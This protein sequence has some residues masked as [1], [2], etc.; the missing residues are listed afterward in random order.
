MERSPQVVIFAGGLGTRLREETEFRPKPMVPVGPEPIL[1]HIMKI[2]RHYGFR[3]FIICLGYKG[4]VIREYFMANRYEGVDMTIN[5]RDDSFKLHGTSRDDWEVTLVQTGL[6]TMTG[7]R[8][9]QV[10]RYIDTENFFLTYGDGVSDVNIKNLCA[11]HEEQGKIATLTAVNL[12]S[13]FG[14]ITIDNS[15]VTAF[16]EKVTVPDQWINGGF[17]MLNRKVFEYCPNDPGLVFETD[18]LPQL[19]KNQQ[20]SAYQHSGFWQCMDTVR[21]RSILESLWKEPSP[22]WKVWD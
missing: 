1:W 19:V 9:A 21:D 2:Y 16:L 15:H 4:D 7:G 22:P 3:R 5:F 11:F 13:R 8:L 12:P 10:E 18:V 20:L 6:E 14:S 17:F